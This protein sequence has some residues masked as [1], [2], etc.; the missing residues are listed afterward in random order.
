MA[1]NQV[2]MNKTKPLDQVV[3]IGENAHNH[4]TK[5]HNKLN[6][7]GSIMER[8]IDFTS[9]V[10]N[11]RRLGKGNYVFTAALNEG[12]VVP[13]GSLYVNNLYFEKNI[14]LLHRFCACGVIGSRARLRIWFRKEWGFESLHAHERERG[15]SYY[16][17]SFSFSFSCA[18]LSDV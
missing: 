13:M 17:V 8:L 3:L 11:F 4:T 18:H 14:L 10:P 12:A 1:D 2:V 15:S 6:S 9:S 7:Q 16:A 5:V